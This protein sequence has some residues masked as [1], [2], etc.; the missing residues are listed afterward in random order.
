MSLL[1]NQYSTKGY[2]SVSPTASL[3]AAAT[4]C[5]CGSSTVWRRRRWTSR[6]SR[7]RRHAPLRYPGDERP[8]L[9]PPVGPQR[10]GAHVAQ[11]PQ[12]QRRLGRR[13]V[14]VGLHDRHVVVAAHREVDLCQL[15]P[16]LL[17]HA[18]GVGDALRHFPHR[19]DTLVR[20]PYQRDVV[21]HGDLL[22]AAAPRSGPTITLR[23]K[24]CKPPQRPR[25]GAAA[26]RSGHYSAGGSAAGGRSAGAAVGAAA[27]AL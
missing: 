27:G 9:V 4:P 21:G 19:A 5:A 25:A 3:S 24:K 17:E 16:I 26:S 6:R 2:S 23:P 7:G 15:H 10:L 20:E 12:G 1:T 13:F 11:R 14:A 8:D 18:L 22:P